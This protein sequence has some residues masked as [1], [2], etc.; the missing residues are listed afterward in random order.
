V[1][2]GRGL[3]NKSAQVIITMIGAAR[4]RSA[5]RVPIPVLYEGKGFRVKNLLTEGPVLGQ[6]DWRYRAQE[7]D[8]GILA[9]SLGRLRP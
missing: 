1:V 3:I 4:S 2:L 8:R 9:R 7:V 5:R 6:G